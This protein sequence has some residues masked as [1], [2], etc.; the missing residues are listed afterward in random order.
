M[1]NYPGIIIDNNLLKGATCLFALDALVLIIS[2]FFLLR[3]AGK[4]VISEMPP[5]DM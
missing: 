4:K 3:I 5:L 1:K 2:G